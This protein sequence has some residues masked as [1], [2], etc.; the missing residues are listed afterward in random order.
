[1]EHRHTSQAVGGQ[2]MSHPHEEHSGHQPHGAMGM[3]GP[4]QDDEHMVHSHGQHAG[5]SV[6]M[7]KNRFWLTLA[8][9]VPVVFFSPMF[10]HLLGYQAAG[11]SR[12]SLDPSGAGN[13]HLLLRRPAVPQGR[14]E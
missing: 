6:A 7:F 10:G 1:M 2:Q 8:L 14:P 9:A 3:N 13:G 5:H 12:L 11:V 4:R